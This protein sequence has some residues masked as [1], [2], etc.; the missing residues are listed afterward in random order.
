[1]DKEALKKEV[2]KKVLDNVGINGGT[3]LGLAE[4]E[5]KEHYINIATKIIGLAI[6]ALIDL[7]YK[8]EL[9]LT[10]HKFLFVEDG[11]MD[12]DEL[13]DIVDADI[14]VV[15]CKKGAGLPRLMDMKDKTL[16]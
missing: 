11:S 7:G 2:V 13:E 15:V 14:K 4:E 12:T 1:M 8:K 6:D 9:P 16:V 5:R 3:Y 10:Y